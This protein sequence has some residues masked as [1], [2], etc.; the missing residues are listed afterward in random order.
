MQEYQKYSYYGPVMLFD[1][2]VAPKWFGETFAPSTKR[3]KCNLA[4]QYK[5]EYGLDT[6]AKI[7]LPGKLEMVD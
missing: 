4:F 1:T 7:T 2:I 3:A 5:Q 6:R